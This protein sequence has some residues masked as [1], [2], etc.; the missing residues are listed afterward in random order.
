[1]PDCMQGLKGT[2]FAVLCWVRAWSQMIM[3][4]CS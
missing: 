3:L 4:L 1:M 2:M